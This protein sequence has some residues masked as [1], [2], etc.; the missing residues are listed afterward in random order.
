[1]DLLS[2]G[3]ISL[4]VISL[5]IS[6]F[7]NRNYDRALT[8]IVLVLILTISAWASSSLS[9]ASEIL[10]VILLSLIYALIVVFSTYVVGLLI[11]KADIRLMD[12]KREF[13]HSFILAIIFGWASG[14][15]LPSYLPFKEAISIELLIL[16]VAAG[17][18]VGNHFSWDL[19][20][21]SARTTALTLIAA[22]IGAL[23]AGSIASILLSIDLG[24]SWAI[25]LGMGWYTYAGPMIATYK[26]SVLG[27]IAF[28]AN[29]IR[30]QFTFILIPLLKGNPASLISI[31]GATTM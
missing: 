1:M 5:G 29:F 9:S 13:K 25:C 21:K 15:F 27:S 4:F 23:I 3:F 2:I 12:T 8:P 16:A 26:G 19:L 22:I 7:L 30:E 17:I 14:Y 10:S 20:K 24:T 31:G 18:A 28:L 11:G 6:K